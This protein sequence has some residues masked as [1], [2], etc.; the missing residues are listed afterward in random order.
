MSLVKHD[1]FRDKRSRYFMWQ[2]LTMSQAKS[3]MLRDKRSRYFMWQS[4][5][6]SPIKFDTYKCRYMRS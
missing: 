6:M 1:A 5:T 3:G 2:S 4:L